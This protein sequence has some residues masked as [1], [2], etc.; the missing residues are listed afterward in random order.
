MVT[1]RERAGRLAVITMLSLAAAVGTPATVDASPSSVAPPQA[2]PH[3][4]TYA[5]WSARW[6][7]WA[8][9][10]EA[11]PGGPFDNGS[12]DCGRHQPDRRVWFLAGPFNESGTVDRSCTVPVGTKLLIPVINVECSN[13][14]ADPF[15]GATPTARAQ[16][17]S[18]D[19][20]AFDDLGLS[21]DGRP[22]AN[23]ERF[24]VISPDFAFTGVPGNPVG[25]VG[26]ESATSRGVFV[27]LGPLPPGSH[28]VT[29]TG[30][31]PAVGF[32]ATATYT[33]VVAR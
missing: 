26:T 14:E 6:W 10:T 15:F 23:L 33:L 24:A 21:V 8:F 18:A 9:S 1:T 5:E 7:Q 31:F 13:L 11:T 28:T 27:M 32:T 20:F 30:A 29:F 22:I 25:V 4:A 16:C 2:R 3:G 12:I 17:V 19:L